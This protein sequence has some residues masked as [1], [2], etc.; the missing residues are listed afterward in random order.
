MVAN[1]ENIKSADNTTNEWKNEVVTGYWIG[2]RENKTHLS[3]K[4]A[5]MNQQAVDTS[6]VITLG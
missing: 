1:K 3:N 6:S 2:S 4:D 5:Q